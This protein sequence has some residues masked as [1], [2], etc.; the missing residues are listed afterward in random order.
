MEKYIRAR[1]KL[2][3]PCGSI[4]LN[5]GKEEERIAYFLKM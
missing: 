5:P 4:L 1:R 3:N 2:K